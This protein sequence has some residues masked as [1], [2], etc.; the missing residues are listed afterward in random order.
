MVQLPGFSPFASAA[1]PQVM[2]GPCGVSQMPTLM[3]LLEPEP[4]EIEIS[5]EEMDMDEQVRFYSNS[6]N[7]STDTT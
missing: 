2:V 3:D 4:I 7:I 1:I 6:S 5:D